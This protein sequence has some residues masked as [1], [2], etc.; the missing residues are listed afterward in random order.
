MRL[1]LELEGADEAVLAELGDA[2]RLEDGQVVVEIDVP[3]ELPE[4]ERAAWFAAIVGAASPEAAIDWWVD[5]VARR[6]SGPHSRQVYADPLYHRPNF[7]ALLDALRL[8]PD[9]ELLEIGCGG[10]AFLQLAL[11]TVARAAAVDHSPEMLE[12]AAAQNADALAS[13]A[14]R[15]G[16]RRRGG[17]AVLRR[18]VQLRG[19][20]RDARLPAGRGPGLRR[21]APRPP[22]R[23]PPRRLRRHE[24]AA[25]HACRAG[26]GREPD[27]LLRGRRAAPARARGRIRRGGGDAARPA[28]ARAGG[29]HPGRRDRLLRPASRAAGRRGTSSWPAASLSARG[30][31]ADEGPAAR[32]ADPRRGGRRGARARRARPRDRPR[33]RRPGLAHLRHAQARGGAA[34]RDPLDRPAPAGGD[35]RGGAARAAR[36]AERRRRG[37]RDP[38]PAAAAAADRRG[39]A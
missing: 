24:G 36:G 11:E 15:A 7:L 20:D 5:R 9:D 1:R 33:R 31:D 37:R 28:R 34:G 18:A 4:E 17:A 21:V 22:A 27:H 25:G 26:A 2:A 10:G 30:S 32:G 6:P 16:L 19:L 13:R 38:R 3:D 29:R 14:A 8:Q 12:L 39:A 35:R 23:G